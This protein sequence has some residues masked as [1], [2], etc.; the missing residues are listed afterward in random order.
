MFNHLFDTYKKIKIQPVLFHTEH[1][2]LY[3]FDVARFDEL[4]P[5]ISGNKYFELKYNIESAINAKKAGIITMGGAFSNHLVAT[6]KMCTQY[7]LKSIGIIRGEIP[8]TLN[9]TLAYCQSENMEFIPVPRHQFSENAETIHKIVKDHPDFHFV[10]MGGANEEG[11]RGAAEMCDMIQDFEQYEIIIC[12]IGTGTML[13]GLAQKITEK[14]EL[15]GITAM[16]IQEEEKIE[17]N[18]KLTGQK[19]IKIFTEY[20]GKGYGKADEKLI[21]F[22]NQMFMLNHLPLD[23]VYTAKMINTI[24]DLLKKGVINQNKKLLAIHSGGLQGNHSLP[25]SLLKF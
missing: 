24:P 3:Q 10:P 9:H 1:A 22:M 16:K 15:I 4:D 5:V 21:D 7:G 8:A 25:K 11:V 14:Q 12:A 18:S 17:F 19:N 13:K 20:A 2:N 6:A 23:F